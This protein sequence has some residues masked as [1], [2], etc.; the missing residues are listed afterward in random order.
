MG[1]TMFTSML[2]E[3]R[4]DLPQW[5]ALCV[6]VVAVSY[7]MLRSRK[8]KDPLRKTPSISLSQQRSVERDMSNLLVE[9]SD[10]ARQISGQLDTRAAK[11]EL[12]I[13]EADEK[14][15]ALRSTASMSA[16]SSPSGLMYNEPPVTIPDEMLDPRHAE[17]YRLCDLGKSAHEIAQQLDQP[18]GEVELILALRPK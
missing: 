18:S 1:Q 17:I 15:A 7:L 2:L 8:N 3:S 5:V 6:G 13:K 14:I 12:L 16:A 9:L 10:M 11:L 4:V